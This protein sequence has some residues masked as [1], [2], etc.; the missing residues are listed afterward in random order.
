MEKAKSS[1]SSSTCTRLKSQ[2]TPTQLLQKAIHVHSCKREVVFSFFY[3]VSFWVI[4]QTKGKD[5]YFGTLEERKGENQYCLTPEDFSRKCFRRNR[6]T[7]PKLRR[8]IRLSLQKLRPFFCVLPPPRFCL[9]YKCTPQGHFLRP[10]S[11][12]GL[13]PTPRM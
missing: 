1:R 7:I 4:E 11:T 2:N 13:G 12:V 10:D 9:R 3:G 5:H 6:H 8:E